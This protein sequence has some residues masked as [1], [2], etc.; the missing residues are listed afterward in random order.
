[1]GRSVTSFYLGKM[2]LH[3]MLVVEPLEIAE[4]VLD[5]ARLDIAPIIIH[6][7]ECGLLQ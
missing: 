6:A 3:I 5:H 4:S 2:W 7:H 1:M